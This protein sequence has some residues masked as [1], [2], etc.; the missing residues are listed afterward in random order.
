MTAS[1]RYPGT[2]SPQ[3]AYRG[4]DDDFG[5]VSSKDKAAWRPALA[6]RSR[7]TASLIVRDLYQSV[8]FVAQVVLTV[9]FILIWRW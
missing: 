8:K 7:S 1:T 9:Y 6:T 3:D 5:A 2:P 4:T